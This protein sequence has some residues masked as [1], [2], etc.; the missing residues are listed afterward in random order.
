MGSLGI[1]RSVLA[2]RPVVIVGKAYPSIGSEDAKIEMVVFED[3]LCYTCR[4]F[5]LEVFPAIESTYV[6]KGVAKYVM[7]PLAFT[8]QSREIANAALEVHYQA[9]HS[10]FP[11]V[12]ELFLRFSGGKVAFTDLMEA[13]EKFKEI[14]LQT[15]ERNVK[16]GRYD[17]E[18]DQNLQVAKKA[19]KKNLRTPA[20]FIN[21]FPMPG[22]TFESISLQ[23]Q[24]ILKGGSRK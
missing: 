8:S 21:G 12:R 17:H 24:E 18:L 22:I 6:E 1:Y 15:F 5:T 9:P 10:Y 4:Y 2:V 3:F 19:M 23:I 14:D 13:A 7:V 11:Y 20:V 16:A